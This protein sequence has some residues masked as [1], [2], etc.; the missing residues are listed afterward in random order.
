MSLTASGI[1]LDTHYPLTQEQMRFFREKVVEFW[2]E[3]PGERHIAVPRGLCA[4]EPA[5]RSIVAHE[6]GIRL[7]S[8]AVDVAVTFV[9][10]LR[11]RKSW[12]RFI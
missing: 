2:R 1:D 4:H 3:H 5:V 10:E 11:A 7:V 6:I 8:V 9:V 12:T